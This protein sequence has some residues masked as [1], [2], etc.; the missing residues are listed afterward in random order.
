MI[1]VPLFDLR[2]PN[3]HAYRRNFKSEALPR[4]A[5]RDDEIAV[6]IDLAG[7]TR[8]QHRGRGV[9]LDQCRPVDPVAGKELSAPIGGRPLKSYSKEH[10]PLACE[11][12]RWR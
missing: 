11:C 5:N 3:Q 1:L 9:L 12:C 2:I 8:H 4:A 6:G 7:I 10:W